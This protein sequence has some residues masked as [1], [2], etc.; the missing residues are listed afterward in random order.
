MYIRCAGAILYG[1]IDDGVMGI[2]KFIDRQGI[3]SLFSFPRR[4][5]LCRA[6]G[7]MIAKYHIYLNVSQLFCP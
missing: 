6:H 7:G 1:I 2:F 4:A 5:V 3:S